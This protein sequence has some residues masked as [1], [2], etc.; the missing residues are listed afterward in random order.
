MLDDAGVFATVSRSLQ[1]I[2]DQLR[3]PK[4]VRDE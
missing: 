1:V 2:Y 4:E 3:V